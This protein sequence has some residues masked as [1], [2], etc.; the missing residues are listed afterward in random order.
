GGFVFT[1]QKG[2]RE[3]QMGVFGQKGRHDSNFNL[4]ENKTGYRG[5]HGRSEVNL[6]VA[7]NIFSRVSTH[8]QFDKKHYIDTNT[9]EIV[10]E[11]GNK[12][13]DGRW[14]SV[15]GHAEKTGVSGHETSYFV[16]TR[17]GRQEVS[18]TKDGQIHS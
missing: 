4:T 8:D 10:T 16:N 5:E 18:G 14:H 12:G 1:S 11:Y 2:G 17:N 9:G 13:T 3:Y 6:D 15:F 7:N